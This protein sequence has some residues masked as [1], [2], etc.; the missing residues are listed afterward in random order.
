M[1]IF[2]FM[3]SLLNISQIISSTSCKVTE[4]SVKKMYGEAIPNTYIC[5]YNDIDYE[6]Y[7]NSVPP[8]DK[9]LND[10]NNIIQNKVY[11]EK[12]IS[13][14]GHT[15]FNKDSFTEIYKYSKTAIVE[16]INKTFTLA[17]NEKDDIIIECPIKIPD[18]PKNGEIGKI[19]KNSDQEENIFN[20][21]MK[22]SD[23]K[24]NYMSYLYLQKPINTDADIRKQGYKKISID[25]NPDDYKGQIIIVLI[26]LNT[27]EI[28]ILAKR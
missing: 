28:T 22:Y 19:F 4:E 21:F 3:L 1:F 25:F 23:I 10:K 6:K 11:I 27:D 20:I 16:L 24:L 13:S 18:K 2:A 12:F 9:P 17:N 14:H 7:D 15:Y 5:S 26:R 8:A